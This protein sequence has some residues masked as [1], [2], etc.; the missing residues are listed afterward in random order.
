MYRKRRFLTRLQPG[1]PGWVLQMESLPNLSDISVDLPATP[2]LSTTPPGAPTPL[3]DLDYDS[4]SSSETMNLSPPSP[5]TKLAP[6]TCSPEPNYSPDPETL[7]SY[8]PVPKAREYAFCP[9]IILNDGAN[10]TTE[11]LTF[12]SFKTTDLDMESHQI[13]IDGRGNKLWKYLQAVAKED[14]DDFGKYLG[15]HNISYP[16]LVPELQ[17][18]QTMLIQGYL[19]DKLFQKILNQAKSF[20]QEYTL[21]NGILYFTMDDQVR[22]CIPDSVDC[23]I[24]IKNILLDRIHTSLGHASYSMTYHALVSY[25]YW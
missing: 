24:H 13:P 16:E 7:P 17:Q 20:G 25:F 4:S 22:L 9:R 21:R 12:K 23:N 3:R 6:R 10:E 14:L 1:V 19:Y 11:Q 8:S 2:L 5:V 18:W 15:V